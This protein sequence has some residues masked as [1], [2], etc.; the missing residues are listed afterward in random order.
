[1]ERQQQAVEVIYTLLRYAGPANQVA[2][3]DYM[4]V[5]G[6][7]SPLAFLTATLLLAAFAVVGRE[8]QFRM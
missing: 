5:T 8:R 2:Q 1:V 3:L 7:T 4:G 6:A